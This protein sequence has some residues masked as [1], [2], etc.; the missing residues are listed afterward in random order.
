[1]DRQKMISRKLADLA[2]EMHPAIGQEDFGLAD[3]ARI[4]NE[5]AGR[6]IA[7]VVLVGQPKVEI[8]ERDPA[9]LAAPAHV[10]DALLVGQHG[11]KFGAGLRRPLG[12]EARHEI[13]AA[14]LD[15]VTFQ[16]AC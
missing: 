16:S 13:E 6:R 9:A 1:Y 5:L 2:G 7:G 4:K 14:C 3:A 8:A 15:A 12:F 10:D 11:T